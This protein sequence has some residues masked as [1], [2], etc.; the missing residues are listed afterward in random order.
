MHPEYVITACHCFVKNDS[1]NPPLDELIIVFGADDLSFLNPVPVFLR[2]ITQLRR[3]EKVNFHERYRY[4]EAY[5]DIGE[6]NF[7]FKFMTR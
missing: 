2:G 7:F 3:I 6:T 4:P 1:N 5:H